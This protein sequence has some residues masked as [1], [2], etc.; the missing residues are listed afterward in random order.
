[1]EP[2]KVGTKGCGNI[3]DTYF[4]RCKSFEG[5]EVAARAD[6]LAERAQAKAEQHNLPRACSVEELLANADIAIVL[7]LTIPKAYAEVA[8]ATLDAG[9]HVYDEKPLGA[10][11]ADGEA[12]MGTAD[13]KGLR[14]SCAPDTFMGAGIQTCRK[15]IDDGWIGSP[16][17]ATAFMLWH[18]HE[19]WHPDP[20]SYCQ[21]GGGPILDAGPTI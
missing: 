8:L 4:E 12:I 13:E 1:M 15:L 21:F 14:M 16:I 2:V 18:G 19:S 3:C 6:L 11:R 7:N 20:T 10:T 9:R 5:V 17:G